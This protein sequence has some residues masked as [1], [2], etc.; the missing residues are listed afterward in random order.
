M[1]PTLQLFQHC[2][3]ESAKRSV[4]ISRIEKRRHCSFAVLNDKSE[5]IWVEGDPV[6]QPANESPGE[7]WC[8]YAALVDL[9]GLDKTSPDLLNL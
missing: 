8:I 6:N 3:Q 1:V 2:H 9:T 5:R 7:A 4:V